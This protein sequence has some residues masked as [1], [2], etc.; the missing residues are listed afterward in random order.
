MLGH[1]LVAIVHV[2]DG[3]L[4][5]M[6][7]LAVEPWT[8]LA[9]WLVQ[10]MPLFF[11]VGGKVNAGSLE[12]ARD[13]GVSATA[14]VRKRTQR[15][16]R[17]LVPLLLLWI[18]LG[19]LL[20]L[21]GLPSGL[22]EV[23]IDMAL[24][25]LWFIVV[26]L[27]VIALAPITR[28]LHLRAPLV[29]LLAAGAGVLVVDLLRQAGV[30]WVGEL[31]YL[32]VFGIAHQ[33]GYFWAEGRCQ[34]SRAGL[35]FAVPGLV[36]AIA[37]VAGAG[38]PVSM[39]GILNGEASNATPPNLAL[40][41]LAVAQ[42]GIVLVL[43]RAATSVLHTQRLLWAGI[44]V[45]G[46]A[47][48]TLFVWHMTAL[49]AVAS[50]THLTGLWPQPDAIDAQWWSLRPVWVLACAAALAPL[51]LVFARMEGSGRPSEGRAGSTLIGLLLAA[52]GLYL[53]LTE[54]PWQLTEP[55]TAPTLGLAMLLVGWLL[56]GVL[57][58]GRSRASDEASA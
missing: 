47:I 15:L 30:T 41:G 56:L 22:I 52:G 10:V 17:P 53:V 12:R 5:V 27:L 51:V 28:W 3:E 23:A 4:V 32:L 39:V 21:L 37:M 58:I 40:L 35:A 31:N 34:G 13:A 48:I 16:L 46:Q 18:V 42:F 36:V 6:Q 9:T 29:T 33:L 7:L 20:E 55:L 2:D 54:G 43:E 57:H 14:W 26:Y 25:P 1:W 8:R 19:S 38:Y 11:L 24:L 50:V 45:V 44:V 49:I